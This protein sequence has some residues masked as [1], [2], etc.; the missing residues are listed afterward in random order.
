MEPEREIMTVKWY[1]LPGET[2]STQGG[3]RSRVSNSIDQ[4]MQVANKE[5]AEDTE[6][7]DTDSNEFALQGHQVQ[8]KDTKFQLNFS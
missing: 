2:L 7:D 8:M 5:P 4:E 3:Q 6:N 1:L